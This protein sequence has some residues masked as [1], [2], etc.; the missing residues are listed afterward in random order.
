MKNLTFAIQATAR[1]GVSLDAPRSGHR[2]GSL[3]RCA[4]KDVAPDELARAEN[5]YESDFVE[6]LEKV[7]ERASILNEYQAEVGDPGYAQRDL[8]RYRH[9]TAAD[10]QTVAQKVLDPTMRG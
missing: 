10:L 7:D 4:L 9:A 2:R 6:R 3:R 5:G 1:P 8:D